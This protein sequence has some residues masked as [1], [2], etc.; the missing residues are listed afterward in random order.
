MAHNTV[1]YREKTARK[2]MEMDESFDKLVN[3]AAK[4]SAMVDRLL[5]DQARGGVDMREL[6][7]QYDPES[8]KKLA[9]KARQQKESGEKFENSIDQL[10][11]EYIN[12]K[13]AS[14]G[15]LSP[16]RE[17]FFIGAFNR[18]VGDE[19][20]GQYLNEKKKAGGRLPLEREA[21]YV[22]EFS[23]SAGSKA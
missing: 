8:G 12:E 9:K 7:G 2:K 1:L 11:E 23:R 6:S 17:A 5:R 13:T 4:E 15:N 22:R 3:A 18:P 21:Y 10:T 14:G 19:I 20:I 16:A